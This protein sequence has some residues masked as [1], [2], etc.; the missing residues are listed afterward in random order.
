MAE[1]YGKPS[2]T[3]KQGVVMKLG[4]ELEV[5]F[6]ILMVAAITGNMLD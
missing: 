1:G 4:V 5:T 2:G 6:P 3:Y